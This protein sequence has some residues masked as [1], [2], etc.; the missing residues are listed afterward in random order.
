[1]NVARA[2]DR[3]LLIDLGEVTAHEL[4]AYAA[5]AR[6]EPSVI[7]CTP[8]QR[9]LF[10][11]FDHEPS[12]DFNLRADDVSFEP[13]VHEVEVRFDGED[14]GE[15]LAHARVTRPEFERRIPRLTARYLGF[16]G[17]WAYLDGWPAEWAMPRR[18]TSRP[19]TRGSFAIAGAVAGFYTIDTPGG[20]NILG[21]TDRQFD[22]APGDE[23][24]IIPTDREMGLPPIRET[25]PPPDIGATFTGNLATVVTKPFDPELAAVANRLVGNRDDAPLL[26][27]AMAGPKVRLH[28]RSVVAWTGADCDLPNGVAF[29]AEGEVDVGRIRNGLRGWLSVI[30]SRRSCG[31]AED[32]RGIR[33]WN[34][35]PDPSTALRPSGAP[36]A[37]D[38]RKAIR[39]LPG[40]H[41][42]PLRTIE[43][44]VTP[45]L[46]RVGIRL[47]PI[48]P[49][50]IKAPAD[51][52]SCGMQFGTI[53]LHPDGSL[54][55]MGPDHP[56]TG[57][58][59]QPLTVLWGERWKL[60]QLTPGERIVFRVD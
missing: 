39:V 47:R 19:V 43:C 40:P 29:E 55:A 38:D 27:C 14:I 15:F 31:A 56:I 26:E 10:V 60:A 8:G 51:L 44:E 1:M 52:P 53:Q 45:Q 36:P 17:G 3:A 11:V 35:A 57:G 2:G 32:G 49:L 41:D 13:R 37:R 18:A 42:T 5:A 48:A 30:P 50:S 16:R 22:I 23:I 25:P 21:R 24:V 4:H 34:E 9:S 28:E 58:Y 6:R 7:D 54:V 33:R 59:L 20:W 46:N 12:L